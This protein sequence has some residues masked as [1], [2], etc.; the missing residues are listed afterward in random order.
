M[1][2]PLVGRVAEARID[3]LTVVVPVRA[4]HARVGDR[5]GDGVMERGDVP[6]PHFLHHLIRDSFANARDDTSQRLLVAEA[7]GVFPQRGGRAI[8]RNLLAG[9]DD[10]LIFMPVLQPMALVVA[11]LLRG[12]ETRLRPAAD[13][14]S[15]TVQPLDF[16]LASQGEAG[17]RDD[18]VAMF[19]AFEL[20]FDLD[21]VEF[22]TQEALCSRHATEFVE[23]CF[24]AHAVDA[25]IVIVLGHWFFLSDY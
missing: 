9:N 13:A 23:N 5:I 21:Q 3:P 8:L 4:E 25:Q 12:R 7:C 11:V 16:L 1:V 20:R 10:E 17:N 14:E 24:H 18:D 19:V 2:K 15:G 22:I 6:E